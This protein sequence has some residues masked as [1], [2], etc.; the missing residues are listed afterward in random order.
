[1]VKPSA[2]LTEGNPDKEVHDLT[3]Y[4]I[5]GVTGAYIGHCKEVPAI[6]VQANTVE[7][8]DDEATTSID[9][10]VTNFPEVHDKLWPHHI[11]A[12]GYAGV[13]KQKMEYRKIE[14]TVPSFG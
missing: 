8:L 14:L 1:M 7:E 6:I 5:K 10:L 4:I 2:F 9:L 11:S 3:L 12:K 13:M